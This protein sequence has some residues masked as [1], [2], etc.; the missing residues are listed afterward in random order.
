MTKHDFHPV[1]C[2]HTQTK[3]D[4]NNATVLHLTVMRVP[5]CRCLM[6]KSWKMWFIIVWNVLGEFVRPKNMTNGSNR[7]YFV[8]NAPFSSLLA[9]IQMLLYP[10]QT[11][12]FMKM[13]AS[14]TWL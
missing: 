6:C 3:K 10:H 8:L 12:N 9:L 7:P 1:I 11:S 14:C 5:D 2:N 4:K 13:C